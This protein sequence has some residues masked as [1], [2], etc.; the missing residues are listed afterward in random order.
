MYIYYNNSILH[1][2]YY[3][4]FLKWTSEDAQ[5]CP[6]LCDPV[7]CSLPSS[8]V[9]GILQARTLE[10]VAISFCRG[11]SLLRGWTRVSHIGG[12]RFN[13][14]VTREA[15]DLIKYSYKMIGRLYKFFIANFREAVV[16][17]VLSSF[18]INNLYFAFFC[19]N[20][21]YLMKRHNATLSCHRMVKQSWMCKLFQLLGKR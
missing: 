17:F 15:Q 11:S 19:R 4:L 3:L 10:W 20:F 12:S 8:S 6:T 9:H 5:S 16:L 21:C 14:W 18:S 13:L 7:D 2:I 1:T